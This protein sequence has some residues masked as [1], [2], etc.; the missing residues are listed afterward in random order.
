LKGLKVKS[1]KEINKIDEY[2]Q[3]TMDKAFE[4]RGRKRGHTLKDELDLRMISFG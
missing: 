1:Q 4:W 2:L 3:K